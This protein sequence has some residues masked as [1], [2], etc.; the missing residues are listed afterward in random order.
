M[1]DSKEGRTSICCAGLGSMLM[2]ARLASSYPP[3]V[4]THRARGTPA[5]S[6]LPV[7]KD[8]H[9]AC[10]PAGN[11]QDID[12]VVVPKQLSEQPTKIS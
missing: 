9:V 2:I 6:I 4:S 10:L 5:G 7:C 8:A 1:R 12:G 3:H 11:S